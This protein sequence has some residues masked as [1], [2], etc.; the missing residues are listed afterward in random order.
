M[1]MIALSVR[2]ALIVAGSRNAVTPLLTASTPVIAVQ[3][4]ANERKSSQTLAPAVATGIGGGGASGAGDPSDVHT[5][6]RPMA[7]TVNRQNT[8]RYVGTTKARPDSRTPRKLTSAMS[9]R[10]ARQIANV[11]G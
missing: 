10:I 6:N 1:P 9:V 11:C 5:L 7:T 2:R 4:L 8:N 3:P